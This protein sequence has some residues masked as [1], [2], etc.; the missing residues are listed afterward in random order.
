M[1]S[2]KFNHRKRMEM[3][4][5]GGNLDRPPVALWRHFPVDDQTPEGLAVSTLSFQRKYEFDFVKVSPASSFCL[6]DWGVNDQWR[7]AKEGTR[8]YIK[9]VIT[10]PEDWTALPVL[11]PNEGHL[12]DQLKCLRLITKELGSNVPVIQT[13]FNPLS[14]AK[15]LISPQ[16]LL[17][18]LRRFPDAVHEGLKIITKIT[19]RFIEAALDTGIAGIFYA[20][21]H[22]QYG[23][24]TEDEY[25]KYGRK[26]D[27][28]V[29]NTA[30]EL[31]LNVLHLHGNEIMYQLFVDYPVD[32]INWHDRET[33][34]SLRE[35]L[36]IFPGVVCG[37]LQ[38][39]RTLVLGNSTDVINE[40]NDALRSTDGKRIILGTGC[41]VPITAPHGNI[42][43]AR[44]SVQKF[45]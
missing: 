21:Q 16:T 12:G 11:D 15:N 25:L 42:V 34:P 37:G 23:L 28:Q 10:K 4:L 45:V 14:Q 2:R 27:L 19:Q 26:Y 33:Y 43:A 13:I 44:E 20:V 17:V 29:L 39:E 1:V 31:W 7:G 40:A 36:K 38:R 3:C 6:K 18:H 22:G 30:E 9:R 5:Q 24:M 35:G 32:V 8:E 41:V